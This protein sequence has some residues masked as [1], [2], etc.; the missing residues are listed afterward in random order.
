VVASGKSILLVLALAA[1]GTGGLIVAVVQEGDERLGGIALALVFG[2][3]IA[4]LGAQRLSR[5]ATEAM[6]AEAIHFRGASREALVCH[7]S[8][9]KH[10]IAFVASSAIAA[11]GVLMWI[12][13][14]AVADDRLTRWLFGVCGLAIAAMFSGRALYDLYIRWG[15]G[16]YVALL[17]EGI[18]HKALRP[19]FVPWEAVEAAGV[20]EWERA[21]GAGVRLRAPDSIE[22]PWWVRRAM[23]LNRATYGFDL[24]FAELE[25][26]ADDVAEAIQRQLLT[27]REARSDPPAADGY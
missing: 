13:R 11:G 18:L 23:R 15:A 24:T 16:R 4:A 9:R 2:A 20:F 25:A 14:D 1:L 6:R 17:P 7:Y 26:S 22:A 8:K 10:W 12:S 19:I 27:A 3:A 5:P 21:R